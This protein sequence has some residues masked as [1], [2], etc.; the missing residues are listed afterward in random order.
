MVVGGE[1]KTKLIKDSTSKHSYYCRSSSSGFWS[2]F[3]SRS[4]I[5]CACPLVPVVCLFLNCGVFGFC[6]PGTDSRSLT[7]DYLVIFEGDCR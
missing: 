5:F 3:C 1:I 2:E 7:W 4:I 6:S